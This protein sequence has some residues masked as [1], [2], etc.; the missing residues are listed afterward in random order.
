MI[1][2]DDLPS[3]LRDEINRTGEDEPVL[4]P[5]VREPLT[6]QF[7]DTQA[8]KRAFDL[9]DEGNPSRRSGVQMVDVA[10]LLRQMEKADAEE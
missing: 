2:L 6:R 7:T 4:E 5:T 3:E 1:Q 10:E 8:R 9:T